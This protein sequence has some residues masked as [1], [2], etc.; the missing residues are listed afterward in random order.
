[1]S[2]IASDLISPQ[3]HHLDHHWRVAQHF[4]SLWYFKMFVCFWKY[5]TPIGTSHGK[6]HPKQISKWKMRW[7]V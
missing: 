2:A 3:I 7:A 4:F 5:A 1:V 6:C